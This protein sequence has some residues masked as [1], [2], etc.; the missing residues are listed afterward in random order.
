[1]EENSS[2]SDGVT[3]QVTADYYPVPTKKVFFS[4]HRLAI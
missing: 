1:M 4:S 2:L 3:Y